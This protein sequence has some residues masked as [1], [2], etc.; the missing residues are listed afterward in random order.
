MIPMVE[1]AAAMAGFSTVG[2][3]LPAVRRQVTRDGINA[4]RRASGDNNR[5]HYDDEFAAGTR[6][7]GVIAHGMLTLTFLSEMMTNAYGANWLSSGSLRIRFRGAAYPDDTLEATGTV[8][9]FEPQ[10]Y[11]AKITCTVEVNNADNGE[12]IITGTAAVLVGAVE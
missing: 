6:F 5:I 9:K 12:K 7:G 11:G 4:Y 10:E 2:D 3:Q 1:T 8:T